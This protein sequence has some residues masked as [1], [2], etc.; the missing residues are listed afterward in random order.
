M[1]LYYVN[2][3]FV[4]NAKNTPKSIARYANDANGPSKIK[5]I[6]NNCVFAVV[7]G[8][9]FIKATK[10]IAAGSE[11]LVDYGAGYWETIQKNQAG[12]QKSH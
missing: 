2:S 12:R 10:N 3:N 5:G 8:R 6:E 9:I 11:I 7:H 1:Y 4:I